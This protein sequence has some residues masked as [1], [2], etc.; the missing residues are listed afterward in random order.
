MNVTA[1][2]SALPTP[3]AVLNRAT[4]AAAARRA[5]GAPPGRTALRVSGLPAAPHRRRVMKVLLQDAAQLGGGQVFETAADEM[6]LL[7][8][9][10]ATASRA[11]AQL[12]T[13][14]GSAAAG[15][16]GTELWRLP[17]DA[18]RLLLWVDTIELS[19]PPPPPPLPPGVAALDARLAALPPERVF[20]RRAILRL[21]R[22]LA[23]PGRRL[24]LSEAALAAELGPLATDADLRRHAGLALARG[25]L[26]RLAEPGAFSPPGTLLLPL[27][28]GSLPPP[29]P[30]PGLVAVLPLTA[31]ADPDALA[32]QR[33]ALAGLGWGLA[34]EGLDAAA[35]RLVSLS[36]IPA[37]WL[38]LRHGPGL[39][40]PAEGFSPGEAA[41]TVLVGCD[42]PEALAWGRARGITRFS[43]A[44]VEAV[45]AA[46]RLGHCREAA[47][48]T[49]RQCEERAS[50]TAEPGRT[51]CRNHTLLDATLPLPGGAA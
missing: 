5:I 28:A 14:G 25:L 32:E 39:T 50:A 51:A 42:G 29:A 13:L 47:G 31:A 6:L 16:L 12:A 44:H 1:T 10:E 7:G 46:A 24:V 37:D 23:M 3:M 21:G 33:E 9:P 4:L 45:L 40:E 34:I 8:T 49:Q 48:C 35:L 11:A 19:P 41:R 15:P 18:R 43:G 22:E 38:L 36:A 27:P 17:E 30:R 20:R 2:G 26:R